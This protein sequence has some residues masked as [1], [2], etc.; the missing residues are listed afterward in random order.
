MH[1]LSRPVDKAEGARVYTLMDAQ[2]LGSS[3]LAGEEALVAGTV[4]R[5][6]VA[7]AWTPL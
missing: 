1:S 7:I 5:A 4:S 6:G 3:R 2:Q